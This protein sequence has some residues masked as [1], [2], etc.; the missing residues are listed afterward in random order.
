MAVSFA[1][2]AIEC[3]LLEDGCGGLLPE[4]LFGNAPAEERDAAI[5]ERTSPDRRMLLPYNC[6]LVRTAE[7]VVLVD[8]GER[9]L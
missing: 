2:G 7:H 8:A 6:L 4:I 3:V 9:A 5:G 1:V